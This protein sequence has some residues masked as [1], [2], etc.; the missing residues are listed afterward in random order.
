MRETERVAGGEPLFAGLRPGP[1]RAHA[2]WV[3][4]AMAGRVGVSLVVPT[5]FEAYVRIHHRIHTGGR[6]A[7]V[8]PEY[9][10]RGVE[11]LEVVGSKLEFIDGDGNL[12]ADDVDALTVMLT[13]ATSTPDQCH[14]ALWLGWGWV[15]PGSMMIVG[16]NSARV[17]AIN[18]AYAKAMAPVWEFAAACPVEQWWGGRDMILFDGPIGAVASIGHLWMGDGS[19]DRQ[20]PQWWWPDDRSWFVGTEI[21]DAWTYVAGNLTLIE[22]VLA[23][24]RWETVRV[25]PT[26]AW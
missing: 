24:R 21:D 1:G 5:G 4:E 10:T 16:Q 18:D 6:W 26:D 19:V 17:E 22:T 11:P 2:A 25:E 7:D 14:Y 12:D 13:G 3:V 23:S 8:A 9:L 15:H 20:S